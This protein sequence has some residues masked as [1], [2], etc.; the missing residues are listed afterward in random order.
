MGNVQLYSRNKDEI[1]SYFD[2]KHYYSSK[3]I[4]IKLNI[5]KEKRLIALNTSFSDFMDKL[6]EEGFYAY[7]IKIKD[8]YHTRYS[9]SS[10]F[11]PYLFA[12]SLASKE[13]SFLSMSSALNFQG[14]TD[15]RSELIFVSNELSEKNT[16]NP[17]L[18]QEDI[19]KAFINASSR[20][21]KNIGE[22][23]DDKFIVLYPKFSNNYEVINHNGVKV[24]SVNRA[25]V[26]MIINVQYFRNT[27]NIINIFKNIKNHLD[28]EK[29]YK[30]V[31]TFDYIYPYFQ[32][33]GLYLDLLGF[34]KEEL[35][36]F[37]A[38]VCKLDFYTQKKKDYKYDP[39]WKMYY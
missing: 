36:K 33:V 5:I 1:L 26:E 16:K 28:I 29:I 37:K 27:D 9:F 19:N 4:A 34:D 17:S 11:N 7:S 6:V 30:I 18:N 25:F 24:S 23:K 32:C 3:N 38:K 20:Y 21:S 8:R 13:K 22:Y 10:E 39:Y 2:T 15:Y 12:I 31:E 35:V 14:L